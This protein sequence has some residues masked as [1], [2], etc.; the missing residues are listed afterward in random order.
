MATSGEILTYGELERRSNRLAHL[1]RAQGLQRGDHVAYLLENNLQYIELMTAA[2]RSGLYFTC[3][4]SYLTAPEVAYILNDCDA[5]LFIASAK[6]LDTAVAAVAD[7][8][9]VERKLAVDIAAATDGFEAYGPATAQHPD[10]PIEDE[11]LGG[12]MLYSSGTTGRPKGVL[13]PLQDSH[14]GEPHPISRF[15]FDMFHFR[16][17]MV[18]LST[19]PIYHSGPQVGV[20][21]SIRLGATAVIMERFDAEQFL[22]L[23]ERHRVTHTQA[24]PTMMARLLKLPEDVRHRYDLSSLEVLHH[25]AAPCPVPIKRDIIEWFGPRIIESYGATEG[26][27]FCFC[28]T[29]EWLAR[30]G[31]VGRP[32]M[33]KLLILDDDGNEVPTGTPGTVWYEGAAH[34]EY[35]KDPVRT[36]ESRDATGMRATVGDIGYV[37]EDGWLY[38][39]DRKAFTIIS[40]GVNVYPQES[41]NVLVTHP[42]VLDAAVI[43]VP[44]EDLGEAVKAVVQLMPGVEP[45]PAIEQELIAFC[46]E[47]LSSIKTPKSVDFVDELPR[48]PTGKLYKRVLREQYWPPTPAAPVV[49]PA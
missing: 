49:A 35:Y 47:Q 8:P 5:R 4:N 17:G 34:F 12:A 37:D 7:A 27:G 28:T 3:I 1:F 38:L 14:P 42:K 16:E 22:A 29:E 15:V 44:D 21:G 46:R 11:R 40:G 13:R 18:Y 24:V 19:A 10:T 20:A 32:I 26:I 25:A 30:P 9:L 23:I 41:E 48:L 6:T 31:T 45:G 33:N 39:T 2:E 43:G 36:A